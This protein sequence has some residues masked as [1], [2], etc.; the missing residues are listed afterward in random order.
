MRGFYRDL[1]TRH[2]HPK[3]DG[4]KNRSGD[5]RYHCHTLDGIPQRRNQ[6]GRVSD[7]PYYHLSLAQQATI[8]AA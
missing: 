7:S 1:P 4:M 2:R 3:R 8:K 5:C 6:R